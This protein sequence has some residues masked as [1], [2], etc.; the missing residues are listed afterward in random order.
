MV[1]EFI[2]TTWWHILEDQIMTV[3]NAMTL[4]KYVSKQILFIQHVDKW[5]VSWTLK[6]REFETHLA[7][8]R[9]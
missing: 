9:Y 5:L 8:G 6:G 4:I 1:D 7:T 3:N 2:L